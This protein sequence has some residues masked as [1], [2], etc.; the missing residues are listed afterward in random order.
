MTPDKRFVPVCHHCGTKGATVHSW[1][2]RSVR[3]LDMAGTRVWL[4]CR[5]RKLYCAGCRRIVIEGLDLF[6][7]Y[8]RITR[9]LAAYIHALCRWMTVQ[10]VAG[11][12]AWTG[13]RSR[14]PTS[15]C[16]RP[17]TGSP[18]I[19]ASASW[20]STRSPSA[21]ATAT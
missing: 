14:P 2:G 9:R 5:Y 3:D 12:W 10:D 17:A 1:T 21:R 15:S 11:P 13:R 4:D 7:P 16:W 20:R 6:D 8:L 18:I 19:R